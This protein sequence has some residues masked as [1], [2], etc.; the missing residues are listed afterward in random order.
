[1]ECIE[2]GAGKCTEHRQV[3]EALAGARGIGRRSRQSVKWDGKQRD[4]CKVATLRRKAPRDSRWRA[5]HLQVAA[6]R[7]A[8]KGR[9]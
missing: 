1:M 2:R 8:R 4:K 5:R 3:P 7:V 9:R 6:I